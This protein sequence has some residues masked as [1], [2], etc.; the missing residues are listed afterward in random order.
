MSGQKTIEIPANR[1]EPNNRFLEIIGAH[2]NN[3]QNIDVR[4]PLGVFV[5]ITGVSGSGK[6]S[7]VNEILYKKLYATFR[8]RRIIPGKHKEIKGIESLSDVR[9]INQSPIG[10]SS[11]SNPATYV[12]FFDSIRKLF[13]DLS[14]AEARGFTYSDFSF[15][16]KSRG[17]CPQCGGEGTMTTVLQYMPDIKSVCPEC[18]GARF[19]KE[20][21]E[22]KY[23]GKN[24]A[25]VLEMTIEEALEFFKHNDYLRHK[26][27]VLNDLGLGYMKLGQSSATISGGEAQRLKLGRELAKIKRRKD[28]LY[29]LDEPTTG[30]HL[31]DIQR[32][33]NILNKLVEEGNTV[34]VV[35][36]HLDVIKTADYVVDLGPGGGKRG[37]RI[38]AQG[39]PEEVAQ[40]SESYTGMYLSEVLAGIQKE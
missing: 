9:N 36:H 39:M 37:G 1:R 11:R 34:L 5:C 31:A 23:R 14:E 28:N 33:L 18:K 17:R 2:E 3:L 7:L 40:C 21:L 32:L 4:I 16:T 8:D 20:T 27:K 29:I 38:V 13:A 19:T 15:N 10:R 6:S 30:L 22:I 24:I 26:L 35:E 12:G 25:E